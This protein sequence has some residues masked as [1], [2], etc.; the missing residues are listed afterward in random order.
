MAMTKWPHIDFPHLVVALLQKAMYLSSSVRTFEAPRIGVSGKHGVKTTKCCCAT[1][2][3]TFQ[4]LRAT[5]DQSNLVLA[6]PNQL[7]A[8]CY[9]QGYQARK[10][11]WQGRLDWQV[12]SI[13]TDDLKICSG[14]N[15]DDLKTF[16]GITSEF[17]RSA[18]QWVCSWWVTGPFSALPVEDVQKQAWK[19]RLMTTNMLF[20]M[21]CHIS[22][23]ES[24]SWSGQFGFISHW[25]QLKRCIWTMAFSH[26]H[27]KAD[28]W[29]P[30]FLRKEQKKNKEE[31]KEEERFPPALWACL[32]QG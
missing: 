3:R 22:R 28:N 21:I 4:L 1:L 9:C 30:L 29:K 15:T 2:W 17:A 13:N 8:K 27:V 18:N 25:E 31:E 16:R 11:G 19:D 7:Q 10:F 6:K 5:T 24:T 23:Y 26:V 14:I 20:A 32:E 12:E